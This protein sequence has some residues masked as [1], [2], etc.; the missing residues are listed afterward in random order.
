MKKLSYSKSDTMKLKPVDTTAPLSFFAK[1]GY[2]VVDNKIFL[3]KIYAMQEATKKHLGP[4]D[5]NWV[6][7]NDAYQTLDW[8]NPPEISLSE[9]YRIRAQQLREK[10]SYLI[11]AF[12]GG[13]DSTNILDAFILNNIRLD[14]VVVYCNRSQC[15]GKYVPSLSE[16]PHNMNS[17]WDYLIEPKLKWLETVSPH[18]KISFADPFEQIK[19]EE[20]GDD[21]VELTV[22]HT[23][24]RYRQQV[25]LDEILL[26]RQDAHKNCAVILG[27]NAPVLTRIKKHCF[28]Q[29]VDA[30]VSSVSSDYTFK[31]LRRN[32]EF[33]YWT[34]DMPEIVSIQARALL[35][36]LRRN[37]QSINLL[38][39][40][41]ILGVNPN[42]QSDTEKLDQHYGNSTDR[43]VFVQSLD[44]NRRRWTK[45]VLYPTYNSQSLQVAKNTSPCFNSE[46]QS[47]FFDNPHAKEIMDAHQSAVVAHQNLID[48]R[49]LITKDSKVHDYYVF[50]S[51][52]Y[53][54][55]DFT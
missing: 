27:I 47:W 48:P 25:A 1:N 22:R 34:P 12:S 36:D 20:P 41:K 16:D 24:I 37:P 30:P 39:E 35:D 31:G 15:A 50:R 42:F 43:T 26:Q 10:Y 7:N 32:V 44:E 18:T 55:G 17:E 9:L 13:G 23:V 6:F 49:F 19:V 33:F 2:Y 54:I 52:M 29:F 46:W 8:K 21:I 51:K 5:I 40:S 14:E 28:V 38:R 3:H 11:L 53:H 4:A 45:Q